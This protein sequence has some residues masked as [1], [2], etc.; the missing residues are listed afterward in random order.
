[1]PHIH[2]STSADL[3]EN[4]DIPE[5]LAELAEALCELEPVS[6]ESVKAYHS[7]HP[8]WAVASGGPAGFCHCDV[9]LLS[10]STEEQRAR[11]ADGVY[12]RLQRCFARSLRAGEA[13]VTL[14]V[15]E[16]DHAAFRG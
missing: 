11:I 9:R 16:V 12:A 13:S 14:E 15:R 10:G 6:G 2:L 7:M 5:V 4:V 8:H 1:M 3:V